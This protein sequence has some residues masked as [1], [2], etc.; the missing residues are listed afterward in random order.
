MQTS[1]RNMKLVWAGRVISIVTTLLF[2]WS[3]IMKLA[4]NPQALQGMNHLG[5]PESLMRPLGVLELLCVVLYLVPATS[6]LGA[7][8][9]T[10]YLGGAILTHLRVGEAVFFQVILGGL[11]WL[12]LYLQESRLR[13][14]LPLKRSQ[15]G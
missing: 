13:E 2:V 8:L 14:L 5:L 7:V 11:L 3:A 6:I 1:I 12:G 10:G 9:F 15:D 4:P